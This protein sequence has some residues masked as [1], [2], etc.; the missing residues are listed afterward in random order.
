M[1][2]AHVQERA[3]HCSNDYLLMVSQVRMQID[4]NARQKVVSEKIGDHTIN[5]SMSG[6]RLRAST[7]TR[8]SGAA[9][10]LNRA[11]DKKDNIMIDNHKHSIQKEI[12]SIRF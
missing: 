12:V 11:V 6:P 3:E 10:V 5:D 9:I 4:I 8:C 1:T 2:G 7:W